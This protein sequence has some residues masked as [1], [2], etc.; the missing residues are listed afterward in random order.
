MGPHALASARDQ[1]AWRRARGSD[2]AAPADSLR[3]A[4]WQRVFGK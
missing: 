4:V 2:G 3:L 1:A